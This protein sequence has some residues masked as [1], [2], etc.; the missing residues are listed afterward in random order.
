MTKDRYL[1][2]D[3]N[4]MVIQN[5]YSSLWHCFI[6]TCFPCVFCLCN[7]QCKIRYVKKEMFIIAW[8]N[9]MQINSEKNYINNISKIP[10]FI[11]NVKNWIL[12]NKKQFFLRRSFCRCISLFLGSLNTFAMDSLSILGALKRI[13]REGQNINV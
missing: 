2:R 10:Y 6:A 13:I 12:N 3:I 9:A 5:F 1:R 8:H 7:K 11:S 4:Q